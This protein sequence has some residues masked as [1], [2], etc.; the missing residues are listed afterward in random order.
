M[1][2]NSDKK[3]LI[4]AGLYFTLSTIITYWFIESAPVYSS[5]SQKLLSCSI[6]G[7]KWAIQIIFALYILQ[8]KKWSFIRNIS[9]TSFIGSLILV[10]FNVSKLIGKNVDSVFF[11][12]TLIISVAVMIVS[13]FLSV[14]KSRVPIL[15]WAGWLFC[16][17]VAIIV[18]LK[19]VFN[20][21][22]F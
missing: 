7:A 2:Q 4:T 14:R 19:V 15:W 8:E 22:I 5:L 21:W 13:Y 10:P 9:I 6:A 1:I 20:L 12:S 11:V 16:L 3:N 18:Q 17:A